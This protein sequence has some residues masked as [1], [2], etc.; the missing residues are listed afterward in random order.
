MGKQVRAYGAQCFG[1]PSRPAHRKSH[2]PTEENLRADVK[3]F[4]NDC[5]GCHRTPYS[6]HENENNVILYPN[7]PQFVLLPPDQPDYQLFWIVSAGIPHS[8]MFARGG[9]F[10]PDANGKDV[11]DQKIW[12]AATF[13]PHVNSLPPSVDS[14]WRKKSTN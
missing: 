12:T 14:E 5:A 13:L 1:R 10:G 11:S 6:A 8:G 4:K 2:R 9:Q 7:A 3:L